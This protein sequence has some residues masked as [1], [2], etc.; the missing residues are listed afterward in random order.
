M[1]RETIHMQSSTEAARVLMGDSLG[2]HIIFV[3]FGLTLPVL[4]SWFELRGILTNNTAYQATA[5]FWSKIMG[6]LVVAGVISGTII[7][8]Q[9]SLVWPGI[10]KFGGEVIGLPFMFE[11]YAFLIEAT[12]LALYLTTWNKV[13]PLVHWLF[14]LMVVV[15]ST[16]SAYVITSVNAWMN[17]PTGFDYSAHTISNVHVWHAMFSRTSVVEFV[18]SMPGYYLTAALIVAGLY[19]FRLAKQNYHARTSARHSFDRVVIRNL[20][21]F[22]AAMIVLSGITGDITGKYL[23]RYEP[24]KLASLELNYNNRDHAPLL[25]GGVGHDDKSIAAPHFEIPSG[26]SLLAGNSPSTPVQGIN[27]F[28]KNQRAPLVIHTFFDLKMTLL[29]AMVAIVAVSCLLYYVRPKLFLKRAVLYALGIAGVCALGMVELGWMIT[30]IGRQPWA[31]RGYVTTEQAI[32]Q[33]H[34]VASLA[35]VFPLG[36]LLLISITLVAVRKIIAAE[37]RRRGGALC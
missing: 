16:A 8:L 4:V 36:F 28:P 25:V 31:V 30:E 21:L 3:L 20:L 1:M 7:A 5:R 32:T 6:L 26:L 11:T 2:F 9:M 24:A 33:S 23:A 14:G 22:S 17:H 19:A 15:G 27:D 34:T 35:Y 10:L 12:F 13:R 18:H 37:Q 29:D